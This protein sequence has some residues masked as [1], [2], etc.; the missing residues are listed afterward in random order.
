M[1]LHLDNSPLNSRGL[2]SPCA[3]GRLR[4]F[5]SNCHI[6]RLNEHFFLVYD[7]SSDF[8]IYGLPKHKSVFVLIIILSELRNMQ[9]LATDP[10]DINDVYDT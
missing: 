6:C 4:S 9:S 5:H 7:A 8:S 2:A 1:S 10:P 3:C